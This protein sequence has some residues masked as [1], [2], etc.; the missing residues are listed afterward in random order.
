[1]DE[2]VRESVLRAVG[3]A[4]DSAQGRAHADLVAK[5]GSVPPLPLQNGL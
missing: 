3:H 4:A 1:V 5:M 2:A